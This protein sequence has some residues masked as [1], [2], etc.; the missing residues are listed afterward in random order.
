MNIWRIEAT[1]PSCQW[2]TPV[3][4]WARWMAPWSLMVESVLALDLSVASPTCWT[5]F[6]GEHVSEHGV[7][8]FIGSC[9]MFSCFW[10][11]MVRIKKRGCT[12]FENPPTIEWSLLRSNLLMVRINLRIPHNIPM[13]HA[14]LEWDLN[15]PLWTPE[16]H[17]SKFGPPEA[18]ADWLVGWL[19]G[20]LVDSKWKVFFF[21][22]GGGG[23]TTTKASPHLKPRFRDDSYIISNLNDAQIK[24][25]L[26]SWEVCG[27]FFFEKNGGWWMWKDVGDDEIWS[28][29]FFEVIYKAWWCLFNA[30]NVVFSHYLTPITFFPSEASL[31]IE[32]LAISSFKSKAFLV[33]SRWFL[34]FSPMGFSLYI[35]RSM[36]R[37]F[38][39][40]QLSS[41]HESN[42]PKNPWTLQWTGLN[43]YSRSRSSNVQKKSETRC[44]LNGGKVISP[45][46]FY[47]VFD[48]AMWWNFHADIVICQMLFSAG[49]VR[50]I[51]KCVDASDIHV[52]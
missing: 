28:T 8:A 21:F 3:N 11:V 33:C 6:L 17:T 18:E 35:F 15:S 14:T 44:F 9:W 30:E 51:R 40:C 7:F 42:Q 37:C 22:S 39:E 16:L 41:L 2:K 25:A 52:G 27:V 19:V 24:L 26:N 47:A 12:E 46:Q 49:A 36:A 32:L 45:A 5:C 4:R 34:G 10:R 38:R 50:N 29:F 48:M 43:L 23:R 20:W 13:I 1:F 31:W